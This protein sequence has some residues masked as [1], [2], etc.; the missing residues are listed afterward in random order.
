[1]STTKL[2]LAPTAEN[3]KHKADLHLPRQPEG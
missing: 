3:R 1:M 2:R